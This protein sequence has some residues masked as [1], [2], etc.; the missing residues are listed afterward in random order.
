[1][2]QVIEQTNELLEVISLSEVEQQTGVVLQ[3]AFLSFYEQ[4]V[5]WKKKAFELKV[6]DVSQVREMKMAREA[7]LALRDIRLDADKTRKRLKEDSLRYGRAVQGVYNVIEAL[8]V[9][10]EQHL[11]EQ[12][13]FAEIQEA[14]RKSELKASREM[15]LQ[16]YA[17]FIPF[18]L[19][20]GSM[21]EEDYHKTL[22]GA[23]LQLQ[24]KLDAEAKAEAARI[25]KEKAD[26]EERERIRI[27]NER[28]KAEAAERERIHAE[29]RAKA[30]AEK[31]KIEEQARIERAKAEEKLRVEQ[32]EK[33]RIAAE[34]KKKEAQEAE[35]KRQEE[36][37]K[38]A[39]IKA[40]KE[41]E[42]KAKKES[43]LDKLRGLFKRL[44]DIEYP[45]M[46]SPEFQSIVKETK[47]SIEGIKQYITQ[48]VKSLK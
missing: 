5:Q 17:E 6:T 19:D 47:R 13:K 20:F 11:E 39:E 45:E 33:E 8:I 25:A 26:A 48:K 40:A 46:K 15:D 37:K 21:T 22:N 30:E 28:L 27:E 16:P 3:D 2:S 44:N 31:A 29:E 14:K 23:K 43:D 4:A 32:A 36:E 42:L 35:F 18:G 10:A 9:P 34:L 41:A 38:Q 7:R 1:M 12:E 24:A